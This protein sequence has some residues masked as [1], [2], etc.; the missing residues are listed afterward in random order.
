MHIG[1]ITCEILRKEIKDVIRKTGVKNIFFVLP[2]TA[3]S[4]TVVL[5]Q[6]VIARFSSEFATADGLVMKVNTLE[7]IEREIR[8]LKDSAIIKVLELRLHDHPDVLLVEI[9]EGVKRMSS[10]VDFIVLGYGLCGCTTEALERVISEASVPVVIPR[11]SK[12][13]I[14]NNCIEIALGREQVQSLL[15][16]EIGTF[17]MTPT[18]AAIIKEPQVILESTIN[19][20]AGRM[21]R[22]TAS[23]TSRILKLMKN[24][25]NRVV[26]IWY[27]EADK[28]NEEYAQTVKQ[29][30]RKFNLDV[31]TVKGS[32]K[33]MCEALESV[34]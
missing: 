8:N 17:F 27:S 13:W 31:K 11:D 34:K 7:K 19:I 4:V 3:N 2:D 30:A 5:Y 25:Y 33:I 23:D 24:H 1:I 21:N 28:K 32:S 20:M 12:G 15:N 29:F 18:G 26:K 16:E 9:E 6:R 14:L 22:H 10:M